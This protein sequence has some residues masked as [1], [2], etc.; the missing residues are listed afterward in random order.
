MSKEHSLSH[1]P[2]LHSAI[3]S[4]GVLIVD[5]NELQR[6]ISTEILRSMGVDLIFEA[7]NGLEALQLLRD[8]NLKPAVILVDLH[9]PRM[10]GIEFIQATA[11]LN[12][13][14]AVVVVSS[15]E[16]ALLDTIASLVEAC[17][18]QMLGSLPKPLNGQALLQHLQKFK[19]QA[20]QEFGKQASYSAL[21][22]KSAI[23]LGHIKPFYQPK[24]S[25]KKA[26]V[27]GFEALARWCD[28]ERDEIIFPAEF[29]EIAND[30]GLLKELTLSLLDAVLADMKAW[31]S[32][33]IFPIISINL[34][35]NL[36][37][38]PQFANHIIRH[39]K[40]ADIAAT[41]ILLEITESALMNNQAAALG[42]I[43]RL[44]LNGFG[45]SIDDYGTGFSSM[46][47]LARIAFS[48]LKID[49]SF[50]CRIND[51]KH[52]ENIVHSILDIGK[53]LGLTTVAEG[54]ETIGELAILRDMGCD[55]IQGYLF[56]KPMPACD[57][58]PWLNDNAANLASLCR[59]QT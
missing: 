19:P 5:D 21:E 10:D 57:L 59:G 49:R 58:L 18:M 9:M 47:Q 56:A 52:M 29:I 20:A 51:S 31:N 1:L 45:F 8:E 30:H 44:K 14:T 37:E 3:F 16:S 4:K 36:L 28:P 41:K 2:V 13:S 27:I 23:R 24:V 48:E 15:A 42:S 53:R 26:Q 11:K 50:I 39:V 17:N 32:L 35:V 6:L 7:N 34:A 12:L 40:H 33:D 54:V 38:D 25:L 43:A 46:Q 22:I 55:L